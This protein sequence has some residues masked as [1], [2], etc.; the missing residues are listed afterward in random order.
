MKKLEIPRSPATRT[1]SPSASSRA[2]RSARSAQARRDRLRRAG[3]SA[4]RASARRRTPRSPCPSACRSAEDRPDPTARGNRADVRLGDRVVAAEHD[5][6][7]PA[8]TT[9][10]TSARS[11][12]AF[13]WDRRGR[14]ARRRSRRSAARGTRRPSPRDAAPAGSSPRGSRAVRSGCPAGPRRGRRSGRRGSRRRTTRAR[15]RPACTGAPERQQ[16]GVVRLVAERL[17]PLEW[18]DRAQKSFWSFIAAP[19]SP[20]ILSLPLM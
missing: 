12:R 10:P 2:G 9:S 11:P 16:P 3:T 7:T 18:V 15:Q 1:P 6:S 8:S 14:P 13:G 17:P 20:L 4:C 19:M 5:G